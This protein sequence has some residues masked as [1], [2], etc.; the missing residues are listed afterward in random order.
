MGYFLNTVTRIW[1]T[2][3]EAVGG[4]LTLG[5]GG[6]LFLG[7]PASFWCGAYGY[8]VSAKAG[9]TVSASLIIG[10]IL[11]ASMGAIYMFFY[12][13]MSNDSFAVMALASVLGMDALIRAW[14]SVTG[15]GLGIAGVQRFFPDPTLESL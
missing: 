3:L 7:F 15:G 14:D 13:R 4:H 8:T 2:T 11:S 6:I 9:L 1:E 12:S 5:V 10:I